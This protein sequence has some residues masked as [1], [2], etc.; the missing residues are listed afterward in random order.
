MTRN[1][2]EYKKLTES[3]VRKLL[4][5]KQFA[6]LLEYQ[7]FG[8]RLKFIRTSQY[9]EPVPVLF[10]TKIDHIGILD[11][12]GHINMDLEIEVRSYKPKSDQIKQAPKVETAPVAEP[13]I[14]KRKDM[15]SVPNNLDEHLNMQQMHILRQIESFGWKLHFL[16]RQL[17]Q[18]PVPVIISP[19]GDKF[20]IL[21]RDGRLNVMPDSALRKKEEPAKQTESTPSVPVYKIKQ[22]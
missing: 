9:K 5:R 21:E 22:A 8:W 13:C 12:D 14:E 16:R 4:N 1:R 18:E 15:A 20:A 17:F 19:K 7:H 11:P 6:S 3:Y 10:N 2:R